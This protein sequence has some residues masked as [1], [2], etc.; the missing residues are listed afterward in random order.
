MKKWFASAAFVLIAMTGIAWNC[1]SW[2]ETPSRPRPETSV[3]HPDPQYSADAHR[4]FSGQ[5]PRWGAM[6]LILD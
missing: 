2:S 3:T 4:H 6:V 5:S 1:T